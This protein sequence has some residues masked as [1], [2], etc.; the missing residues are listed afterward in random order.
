MMK[1]P[2]SPRSAGLLFERVLPPQTGEAREI[3][4]RAAECQAV[5]DGQRREMSVVHQVGSF[6]RLGEESGED[7]P[8]ELGR[9]GIQTE[10]SSSQRS[11]CSQAAVTVERA[12]K[13]LGLAVSRTKASNEFQGRPT[14]VAPSLVFHRAIPAPPRAVS[15]R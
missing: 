1:G 13:I 9:V 3:P 4:I 6:A 10:S 8:V 2:G 5:F 14:R 12:P 7:L 15:C 11:T